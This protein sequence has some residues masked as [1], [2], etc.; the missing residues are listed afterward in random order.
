M[1]EIK[2]TNHH[3][4]SLKPKESTTSLKRYPANPTPETVAWIEEN[5]GGFE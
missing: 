5:Y 3:G 1:I 4:F 2:D